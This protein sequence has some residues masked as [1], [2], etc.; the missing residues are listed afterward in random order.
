MRIRALIVDDS[1]VVRRIVQ[2]ALE[3]DPDVEVVGAAA[4]GR[5]GVEL[6]QQLDPDI[7]TLDIEMPVMDGL[8]ALRAIRTTHPRL[9]VI[10]FSTL[11]RRGAA[12]T[13]DALSLG[14]SDYVAKP[15][16]L[17]SLEEA[18][19]VLRSELLPRVHAL[20]QRPPPPPPSPPPA[21]APA[22]APVPAP[23]IR[24][25]VPS[26]PPGHPI[27]VVAIGVSTG[28]PNALNDVIPLLPADLPAPVLV[29]QHMPTLFTRIL[30]DRLDGRS[31]LHVSEAA[32][33]DV[34]APGGVWIAPGGRHM[35]VRRDRTGV[36]IAIND[37]PP[38]N[39]CRPAVD[40]MLRSV[41][42]AYGNR[43]LGVIMTGMGR[44]GL[45]GMTA[46]HEA[47]GPVFAQDEAS[48]VVWGMPGAV[49]RSG[50]ADEVLSLDALAP[51]IIHRVAGRR[52]SP[53]TA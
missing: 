43:A 48:S 35:V 2:R 34:V 21:P 26:R 3:T 53:R 33:G 11:T 28:G 38:E 40:P 9:P 46:L 25:A 14:A 45:Q 50:A 10:M 27:E 6:V 5:A 23:P 36:R 19:E 51:A 42:A 22:P 7:V 17:S 37:D 32:D 18:V 31:A 12:T 15:T 24:P 49:A 1:G 44:D 30:A 47:G 16:Q 13:L 8:T 29:V 41:V 4:D 20:A 39:S 52:P